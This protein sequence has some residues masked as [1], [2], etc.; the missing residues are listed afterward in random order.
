VQERLLDLKE[1]KKLWK[2][3]GQ[4]FPQLAAEERLR[5]WFQQESA[6]IRT[7]RKVNFRSYLF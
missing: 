5:G 4:F 6:T 3:L 2:I 7:A 1:K